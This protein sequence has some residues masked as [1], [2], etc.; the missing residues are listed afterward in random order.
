MDDTPFSDFGKQLREMRQKAKESIADVSGAVEVDTKV[1]AEIEAGKNQPSEDIVL[2]LISHFALKEDEALKMWELAGFEQERTGLSSMVSDESG[3]Q[4]T[5]YISQNDAR[6]LYSDMIH[7]NANQFGVVI[8][9]LQGLGANNQPMAVSRI[10]M[11]REHAQSL[12]DVLSKTLEK[13]KTKPK[14]DKK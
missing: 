1:I 11:S 4:Q 14:S 3:V 2:L 5:A 8:N 12:L 7:V 9:F 6:I 10:G 13:S